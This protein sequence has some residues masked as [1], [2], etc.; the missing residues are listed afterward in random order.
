MTDLTEPMVNENIIE[1]ET[2][3]EAAA[4]YREGA[5]E[6]NRIEPGTLYLVATPIGNMA[7]LSPRA[8]KVLCGVDLVAAE[9]TRVSGMMLR[10]IGSDRPLFSYHEH[11]KKAA[12]RT[13]IERLKDGASCA[14]VTDA[15]TPGISDP[16]SDLAAACIK[17]GIP[18]TSVPGCCAAVNAVI[19]SG[20]DTRRFVFEGFLPS[21]GKERRERIE[22]LRTERRTAVLYEA[23]HRLAK[24]L[25][26]LS[27]AFGG[28]RGIALCREMT[29]LNEEI[30]RGTL[31]EA[32][33]KY[34][35]EDPRGEFVLVL[36]GA[37]EKKEELFWAEMTVEEHV[38][39][40]EENGLSRMDA[41]KAAA[42]DRGVGKG[43]IYRQIAKKG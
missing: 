9:D 4:P 35:S 37:V 14:V 42:R 41:M 33:E 28:E 24:T 6:K 21:E 27:A 32:A 40:Y 13:L 36:S 10:N 3:P 11:N 30:F 8:R 38:G 31:A 5:G 39:F 17:E 43:E 26:E 23:P 20:A 1:N 29:K 22:Y 2:G 18:V 19:L 25:A 7:D 16:G 12:G 34:S 15:G